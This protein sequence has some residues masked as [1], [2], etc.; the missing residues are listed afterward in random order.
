[1]V[2]LEAHWL[3]GDIPSAQLGKAEAED[4]WATP[5]I[6]ALSASLELRST[7]RPLRVVRRDPRRMPFYSQTLSASS[8]RVQV[9]R[10]PTFVSLRRHAHLGLAPIGSVYV[11]RTQRQQEPVSCLRTRAP[12]LRTPRRTQPPKAKPSSYLAWTDLRLD[13]TSDMRRHAPVGYVDLGSGGALPTVTALRA[14]VADGARKAV[15]PGP[16]VVPLTSFSVFVAGDWPQ[17][18]QLHEEQHSRACKFGLPIPEALPQPP[19]PASSLDRLRSAS[20][21][22]KDGRRVQ[23]VR[24]WPHQVLLDHLSTGGAA[25]QM[26]SLAMCSC[27][28][29]GLS[30]SLT[31]LLFH[32]QV[33][34][35]GQ[36]GW[37]Y[38]AAVYQRGA[39]R[40][41][42]CVRRNASATAANR[43]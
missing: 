14:Y 6:H 15:V 23:C 31:A 19:I 20:T 17:W 38:D 9:P 24:W 32:Y 40:Y 34:R 30:W 7:H 3:L 33:L 13:G 26:V 28:W 11:D 39:R 37:P 29:C 35:C 10:F 42:S 8:R 21:H 41:H 16:R 27:P 2:P 1:M 43:W 22:R 4:P 25:K 5:V 36:D 12:H 18:R